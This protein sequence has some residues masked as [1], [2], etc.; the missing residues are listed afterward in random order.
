MS[1]G[2]KVTRLGGGVEL[3]EGAA[4]PAGAREADP[5][6]N[7]PNPK[8]RQGDVKPRLQWVPPALVI[9]AARAFIEGGLPVDQGGRGYGP[10]N[11]RHTKVEA[12]TY[13]GA[14]QRHLAAYLDGEDVDPESKMGKLHLEGLAACAA[15]LL[16]CTYGGF[17]IDNRPHAL[18]AG[19]GPAPRLCRAPGFKEPADSPEAR[20]DA[21]G[22]FALS[23][24][25]AALRGAM[26][27]MNAGE[28]NAIVDGT[29]ARLL[30]AED[31]APSRVYSDIPSGG[32]DTINHCDGRGPVP[33]HSD[34][35]SAVKAAAESAPGKT[36]ADF[37]VVVDAV[38]TRNAVCPGCR[39]GPVNIFACDSCWDKANSTTQRRWTDDLD[40][41]RKAAAAAGVKS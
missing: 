4:P 36:F 14:A 9:G 13:V 1:D 15:I 32:T 18:G 22:P 30:G 23:E 27:G 2:T 33:A 26:Q 28:R 8:Q 10:F 17:L 35:A 6:K 40:A 38:H 12:L 19:R 25:E 31:A 34:I 5:T 7:P 39:V 29:L 21:E 3:I 24:I 20:Q 41:R 11:W 37:G 16:D